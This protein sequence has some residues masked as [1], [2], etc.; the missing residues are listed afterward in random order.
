MKNQMVET[1]GD[2]ERVVAQLRNRLPAST[3]LRRQIIRGDKIGHACAVEIG[4]AQ[5]I[6]SRGFFC[7]EKPEPR[8][9]NPERLKDAVVVFS[10]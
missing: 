8:P 9:T 4:V 3:P 7:L 5:W 10:D 1:L 6:D 2:L